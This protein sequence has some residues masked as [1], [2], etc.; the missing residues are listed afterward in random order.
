MRRSIL[1]LAGLALSVSLATAQTTPPTIPP[2]L[3]AAPADWLLRELE[4]SPVLRQHHAGLQLTAVATGQS[5][6]SWHAEQYFTPAS[7]QKLLT[8][9]AAL[10]ILPDSVPS[11]RYL[12]RGDTLL[13]RGT[14]DPTLL[15]GDVPSARAY[16]FLRQWP[17]PLVLCPTPY[18]EPAYGPGWTWD[19]YPYYF[20]PERGAFPIYGHTVR[21]YARQPG[22]APLVLP[23]VFRPWVTPAPPGATS[24][25]HIRRDLEANRFQWFASPKAWVDETPFRTSPELLLTLLRDTLHRPDVQPGRWRLRP[26]EQARVLHGLP[27]DSLYRRT[28]R[29]SDNF[30]AEQTLLLCS[31]QLGHDTLSAGRVIR[32]VRRQGWLRDLPDSTAWVDGS[33]LSR[34]NLTTPR[35]QVALLLK[36]H[37]LVP[38]PRLLSLLAAGGGQGTLRRVYRPTDRKAW[39]WGKTGTLSNNHTLCGYLRTT[40]GQL[41]AFSFM[42][43]NH[44]AETTVVRREMERLLTLVHERL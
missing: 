33:G 15:H 9:Y 5:L 31:A 4:A 43:N 35:N 2:P 13:F 3:P 37:Q 22:R 27:V 11:L 34:L 1:L 29:V 32:Y 17:G 12:V 38:E 40:S 21:F 6:L 18:A 42:N 14:G 30:L 39:L 23:R 26:G 19:D 10:R 44:L 20:Q 25:D 24:P 7:T 36:L 8:L 16:Q 41:L 28:I